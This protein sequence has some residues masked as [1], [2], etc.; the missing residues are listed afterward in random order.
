MELI[1]KK[2]INEEENAEDKAVAWT[3]LFTI[4]TLLFK[5]LAVSNIAMNLVKLQQTGLLP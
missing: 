3:R 1:G 4:P 5:V 2:S